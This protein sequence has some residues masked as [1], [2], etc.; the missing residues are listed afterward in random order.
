MDDPKSNLAPEQVARYM[1]EHP[2]GWQDENGIDLTLIFAS[3]RMTPH[4]RVRRAQEAAQQLA[5]MLDAR[6]YGLPRTR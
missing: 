3:L 4:E 6:I 2:Y 5:R 1:A